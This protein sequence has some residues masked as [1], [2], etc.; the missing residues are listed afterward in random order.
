MTPVRTLDVVFLVLTAVILSA[1]R[2]LR[3]RP[4]VQRRGQGRG[5]GNAHRSG[6]RLPDLNK[7]VVALVGTS[8][9]VS[10]SAPIQPFIGV[11]GL[12]L[13]DWA[14]WLRLRPRQACRVPAVTG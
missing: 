10:W 14:L 9:A 3:P 11:L 5:R 12:G 8:G 2:H 1:R 7:A 6:D 13:A 4:R